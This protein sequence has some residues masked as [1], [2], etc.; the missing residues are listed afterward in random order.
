MPRRSVSQAWARR[1]LSSPHFLRSPARIAVRLARCTVLERNACP[2]IST[3]PVYAHAGESPPPPALDKPTRA[4]AEE[5]RCA[6]RG[7]RRYLEETA[8]WWP[9][10]PAEASAWLL[11]I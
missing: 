10:P 6:G 8:R 4:V 11:H 7:E 3:S 1:R 5:C 9:A 2:T